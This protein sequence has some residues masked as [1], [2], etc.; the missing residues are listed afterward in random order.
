MSRIY[1][2][3]FIRTY[4]YETLNMKVY[5]DIFEICSFILNIVRL[6]I[7]TNK[8]KKTKTLKINSV[9]NFLKISL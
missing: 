7:I 6:I 9:P 4:S 8:N 5:V 3:V 1:I 2:Y